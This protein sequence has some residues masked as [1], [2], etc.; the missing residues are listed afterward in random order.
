VITA[1]IHSE[2][3]P[4]V[5][6]SLVLNTTVLAGLFEYL[7]KYSSSISGIASSLR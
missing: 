3:K 6:I 5:N 7:R 4:T 1:L 2:E